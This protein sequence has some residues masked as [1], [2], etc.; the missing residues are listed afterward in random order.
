MSHLSVLC[1]LDSLAYLAVLHFRTLV[2]TFHEK[3]AT[4]PPLEEKSLFFFGHTTKNCEAEKS[5]RIYWHHLNC[6]SVA[7]PRNPRH[8]RWHWVWLS[9]FVPRENKGAGGGPMYLRSG[10]GASALGNQFVKTQYR[11]VKSYQVNQRPIVDFASNFICA[12]SSGL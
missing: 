3:D 10:R 12:W 11:R 7:S 1:L 4:F 9:N 5:N 8:N 2:R 6:N